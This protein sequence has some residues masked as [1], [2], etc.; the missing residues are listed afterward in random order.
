M[1][2]ANFLVNS[3]YLRLYH[4]V[5]VKLKSNEK[6]VVNQSNLIQDNGQSIEKILAKC[7]FGKKE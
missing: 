5:D 3:L 2:W 4:I 1:T 6:Y 7:Q